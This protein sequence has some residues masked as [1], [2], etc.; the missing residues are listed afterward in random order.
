MDNC[1]IGIIGLGG[2]AELILEAIRGKSGV[3]VTAAADIDKERTQKFKD[4]FNIDNI[5]F[6]ADDLLQDDKINLVIIATPPFLHY[7]LG[8]KALLK[9]KHIF[10]E[11]PG[12]LTSE[13]MVKLIKLSQ[14]R[15]RKSSI[16][17]VMRRNPLYFILKEFRDK[18]LFGLPERAYLENYAHD[19]SLPPQH[20]F[21]DPE[22]SGGIWVEHGVHFFDLVNWLIGLPRVAKGEKIPR[23]YTGLVDRVIGT[24]LHDNNTVVSY[25]HGFTKPEIFEDT[26]FSLVFERAYTLA[27]GWIPI[28][29]KVDAMV[30]HEVEK[31]IMGELLV[32]AQNSLPGIDVILETSLLK[33]FH[34]DEIFKGRGKEYGATARVVFTFRL[35]KNRWDV[36]KACVSRG[37]EDMLEAIHGKKS[38]P[39]VTLDDAKNA[40]DVAL[41]MSK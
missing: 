23:D 30:T 13:E 32:K 28:E 39:D 21:W 35:N 5:Y 8:K 33:S 37:I 17:F 36:Y 2:F 26:H 16:D 38:N 41:M 24:A 34:R 12:S 11:K 40:L 25:Y 27:K 1:N 29:L 9:D 4:N 20:W 10:L 3:T 18:N 19:D 22:K 6:N 15:N 7:E 14:E 31:Y